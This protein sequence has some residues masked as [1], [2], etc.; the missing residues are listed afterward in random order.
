MA[1]QPSSVRAFSAAAG[2]GA[3]ATKPNKSRRNRPDRALQPARNLELA[4]DRPPPA[5]SHE[6][7][8]QALQRRI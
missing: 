1:A 5:M 8:G 4:Y 7:P 3:G 6:T 2:A